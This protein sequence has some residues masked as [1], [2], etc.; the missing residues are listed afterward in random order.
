MNEKNAAAEQPDHDHWTDAYQAGDRRAAEAMFQQQNAWSGIGAEGQEG[1]RTPNLD[2]QPPMPEWG[3]VDQAAEEL[4]DAGGADLVREWG[5]PKSE[6]FRQNLAFA[7]FAME[8]VRKTD[9]ELIARLIEDD[10]VALVRW[11]AK[12]GRSIAYDRGET[13]YPKAND[14]PKPK[15]NKMQ[16]SNTRSTQER[17][18][19]GNADR[20]RELTEEMHQAL[21]RGDRMRAA[22][23]QQQRQALSRSLGEQPIVGSGQRYA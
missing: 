18:S 1:A 12:L 17:R 14:T 6:N 8:E 5:G 7:H 21:E 13:I 3:A 2:F 9:P 15:G 20:H 23:L 11:A 19:G 22:R 4:I 10:D 16:N